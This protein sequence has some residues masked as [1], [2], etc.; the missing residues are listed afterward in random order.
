[1]SLAGKNVGF[2]GAGRMATALAG[3]VVRADLV[4]AGMIA[5]SDPSEPA[6]TGFEN[7]VPGAH[8]CEENA[9]VARR[10]DVVF[11]A[12]KPNL[13]A[14]ALESVRA[15]LAPDTLVVSIA[16]GVPL[17]EIGR[18]LENGAPTIRAMPNT[19]CLV[20]MSATAY[21]LGPHATDADARAVD[22]L[23]GAVGVARQVDEKLLDAVTGL[24]GSGPGFVYT[25][26]EALSDGGVLAGLPRDLANALAVQTVR[27]AAEMVAQT[28]EHPAVLRDRVTSPGGTTAAG[29]AAME[30]A[31]VRAALMAAVE[32]ASRRSHELGQPST[33]PNDD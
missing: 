13:V 28:G 23:F 27:G 11:V 21:A 10:S 17:A 9:E 33:K 5:A 19:P 7:A 32:E 8:T 14:D 1:M 31:G 25:V 16:A 29:L 2:L 24:S 4:P 12:V 30:R 3:G 15:V 26:I 20:G 6:R 22:A 18:H